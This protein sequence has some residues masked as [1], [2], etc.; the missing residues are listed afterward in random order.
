MRTCGLRDNEIEELIQPIFN[1]SRL[2]YN[3][4][5][6]ENGVDIR[7]TTPQKEQFSDLK[8]LLINK[9]GLSIYSFDITE[10]IE[11]AISKLFQITDLDMD[12]AIAESCTGGLIGHRLTQIPNSSKYFKYSV[13]VYSNFA[14]QKILGISPG[15]LEK[16]G[17]VSAEIAE[18]MASAVKKITGTKIGLSVTGIAGPGGGSVNKPVGLVFCGLSTGIKTI[19]K[20]FYFSGDRDSIKFQA[21]QMALDILRTF[22]ITRMR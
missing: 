12:I 21:S 16:Y 1:E 6:N 7:M 18:E 15:K 20:S 13:V 22:L 5:S 11:K 14:K 17:A 9:L 19:S 4:T 10:T 2:H 8:E 3:L